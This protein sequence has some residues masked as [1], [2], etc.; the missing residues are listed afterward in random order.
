M[1][2][3]DEMRSCRRFAF[4][5]RRNKNRRREKSGR[6][7]FLG[8]RNYQHLMSC[9]QVSSDNDIGK[10]FQMFI[11]DLKNARI[12]NRLWKHPARLSPS[13]SHPPPTS[14]HG[15][16][17]RRVKWCLSAAFP[18]LVL[19]S[20]NWLHQIKISF[21]CLNSFACLLIVNSDSSVTQWNTFNRQQIGL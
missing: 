2:A 5:R 11:N 6:R 21:A 8:R 17:F 18:F 4:V 7:V 15:F 9:L 14:Q 1:Q 19:I 16:L 20:R 12:K 10:D 13:Q 3:S